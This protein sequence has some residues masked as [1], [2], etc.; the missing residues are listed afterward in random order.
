LTDLQQL[1]TPEDEDVVP[2]RIAIAAVIS[3]KG[4]AES[5]GPL[6]DYISEQ[7][8]RPVER[9]QRRTYAEVN[10]LVETGEVD[11]AFVCTSS[12]II[13]KNDF[14]MQLLVAPQVNGEAVYYAQIIV[15]S[16][17]NAETLSDLRDTVFAFT[18]PLSFSGRMHP[19]YLLQQIGESPETFFSQT[20]F[21]YSHD[22]AIYAVANGLAEGASVDSLVLD[23]LLKRDPSIASRIR[24][25]HT[26]EPFGIPPVVVGPNIRPQ[27]GAQL[28]EILLNAH[29]DPQ[30][31]TA[32]E[33]LDIDKF[34]IIDDEAYLSVEAIESSLITC[35]ICGEE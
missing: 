3:P 20:I 24:V 23:F 21:T 26:S 10:E 28:E 34:I 25:I 18:D 4:S 29:M 35:L 33:E 7:L 17:S 27:L 14:G 6:F 11:L 19:T 31:E 1:P 13:G 12:F 32:L 16:D 5:Y 8:G 22:D 2:L 9:V 15:P 30:G